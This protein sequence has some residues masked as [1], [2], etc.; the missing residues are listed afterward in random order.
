MKKEKVGFALQ[1]LKT[2][3]FATFEE[4]FSESKKSNITTGLEFKLSQEHRRIGVF[5][6]FTF[7]Q[8]KKAYIKIQV[9]CHFGIEPESWATFYSDSKIIFPKGFIAHL[10]MI[11]IGSTRGI[12]HAKTEGTEFNKFLLPAIDVTA[13][14]SQNAEFSL[15]E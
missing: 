1:G 9:S 4:N 15:S 6:T 12:L 2:E 7:E 5:A 3:Q 13:L 11:T 10:T 8:A 14:I